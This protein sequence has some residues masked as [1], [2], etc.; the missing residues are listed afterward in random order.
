MNLNSNLP[1]KELKIN[2]NLFL[3]RTNFEINRDINYKLDFRNNLYFNALNNII[4][5]N[6]QYYFTQ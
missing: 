5:N 2:T 3:N 1:N 4:N 6:R